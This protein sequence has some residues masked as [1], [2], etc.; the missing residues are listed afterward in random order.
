MVAVDLNTVLARARENLSLRIEES[1]AVIEC[2]RLP[3]VQGDPV[4]L[5]LVFQNLLGNALKFH[6]EVPPRIE[7]DCAPAV[8][9]PERYLMVF[10]RDHGIGIEPQYFERIFQ[11]FQRLHTREQYPG[12]GIGLAIC[13]RVIERHGGKIWVEPTPGKGVTFFFTLRRCVS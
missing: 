6:G 9:Q 1:K 10:V 11:L 3:Q 5:A 7:V 13:K 2:G 12:T 8:E 4:Q